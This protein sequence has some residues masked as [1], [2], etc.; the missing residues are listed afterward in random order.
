M[1][2]LFRPAHNIEHYYSDLN[3]NHDHMIN[4]LANEVAHNLRF[5]DF[6][7][8]SGERLGYA[9]TELA[10]DAQHL[11]RQDFNREVAA[12]QNRLPDRDLQI[13]RSKCGDVLAINFDGQRIF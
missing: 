5:A 9:A 11:T 1:S 13:E 2:I 7:C 10:Y 3:H 12:I 6:G 4:H 8:H